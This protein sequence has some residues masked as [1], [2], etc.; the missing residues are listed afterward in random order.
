[1]R[2]VRIELLVPDDYD[3]SELLTKAQEFAVDVNDEAGLED[4]FE[5]DEEGYA[6]A[7]E[8]IENEVSVEDAPVEVT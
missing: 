4:Y 3:N 6:Q 8:N 2:R 1:M 5:G 7:V